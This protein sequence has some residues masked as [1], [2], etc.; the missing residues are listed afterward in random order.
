MWY[1]VPEKELLPT[2]EELG[3]GFVPFSPLGKGMLEGRVTKAAR[4]AA[5]DFRSAIPRF[6]PR[7]LRLNAT[8][9]ELVG[10]IAE[11]FIDPPAKP[12]GS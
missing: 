2:L 6:N 5:D 1:R 7:N 9:G 11:S 8:V 3:I 12:G 4:F 10:K